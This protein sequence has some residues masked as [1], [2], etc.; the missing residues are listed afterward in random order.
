[1]NSPDDDK[2]NVT[3]SSP[4]GDVVP[5]NGVFSYDK[6][7]EAKFSVTSPV[8]ENKKWWGIRWKKTWACTGWSGSG[9]I[10][11]SGVGTS[12]TIQGLQQDS[13]ITFNWV[14]GQ[15]GAQLVSLALVIGLL[16][17]GIVTTYVW[18]H[19][20]VV[21]ISA[22]ALG[23]LAHE[24]VQSGGK[25]VY[26]NVDEKGNF[27]LGGLMGIISG[28]TAGLLTYQGLLGT[29]PVTVSTKLVVAAL[30]AGLAVKALADAPNPTKT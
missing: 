13:A 28:G 11:S 30:I 19:A 2:V 22:G 8:E 10:P 1:L 27:C 21:A 6:G 18:Q 26:P 25:Y 23:G 17:V 4:Y 29:G 15:L 5:G 20:L 3:V 24:V 9:D 7:K 12:V 14:G 16:I